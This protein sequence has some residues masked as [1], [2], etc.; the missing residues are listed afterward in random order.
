MLFRNRPE[1]AE[2]LNSSANK[3]SQNLFELLNAPEESSQP[4]Q[5]V[6]PSNGSTDDPVLPGKKGTE[7]AS[8]STGSEKHHVVGQVGPD[9]AESGKKDCSGENIA[10]TEKNIV[11]IAS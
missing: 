1:E 6:A 11:S 4:A 10:E 7:A 9:K 2:V 8:I 3:Q 5:T